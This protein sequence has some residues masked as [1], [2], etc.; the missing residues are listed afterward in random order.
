VNQLK[1]IKLN[2]YKKPYQKKKLGLYDYYLKAMMLVNRKTLPVDKEHHKLLHA[3][4]YNGTS[5]SNF[6]ES[7]KKNRIG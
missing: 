6:F 5:L 1:R 2:T 3:D 4:K 7:F